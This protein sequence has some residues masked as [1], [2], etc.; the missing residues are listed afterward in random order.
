MKIKLNQRPV[1][2]GLL[3]ILICLFC[4]TS[5]SG[6]ALDRIFVSPKFYR[7]AE[8]SSTQSG[9]NGSIYVQ[10]IIDYYGDETVPSVVRI[11]ATGAL[12]RSFKADLPPSFIAYALKTLPNGNLLV[13]DGRRVFVLSKTGR[14]IKE[15]T[16]TN[17][18][19]GVFPMPD[20]TFFISTWSGELY[21]YTKNGLL[22]K[23]FKNN[24]GF[25]DGGIMAM[26]VQGSKIVIGGSFTK[27]RNT[28]QHNIARILLDGTLDTTFNS[29]G[30]GTRDFIHGILVQPDLKIIPFGYIS[31]YN[32]VWVQ[33]GLRLN[34]DG[35]IDESFQHPFP[36]HAAM[37]VHYNNGLLT[38]TLFKGIYRTYLNGTIDN[39]FNPIESG[40][41]DFVQSLVLPDNSVIVANHYSSLYR[42]SKF[43]SVGNQ[44]IAFLT[45]LTTKGVV[46]T[47]DQ[48]GKEIMVG[49]EF[50][51]VD[52]VFTRN[53]ARLDLQGNVDATFVMDNDQ[54]R[55]MQVDM[56][57]DRS[58]LVNSWADF[59]KVDATGKVDSSFN[60][61][62]FADLYQVGDFRRLA[63]GKIYALGYNNNY[64]LNEDGS[65]DPTFDIAEGFGGGASTFFGF[66]VD[67]ENKLLYGNYFTSYQ[68]ELAGRILR[69]NYDGSRDVTFNIGTGAND[70]VGRIKILTND[71]ILVTG[72]FTEFNG[73]LTP[74]R[75]III[76]PQGG[77]RNEFLQNFTENIPSFVYRAN[78][79][80]NKILLTGHNNIN[81]TFGAWN[82]D[83]SWAN[84][85]Q[86]PVEIS[87]WENFPDTYSPGGDTL[88]IFGGIKMDAGASRT[89]IVRILNPSSMQSFA[90]PG[91]KLFPNPVQDVM[92]V[93]MAE[94]A[95]YTIY[96]MSGHK[97]IR[98]TLAPGVNELKL[99]GLQKGSYIIAVTVNGKIHRS[100]FV[101]D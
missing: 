55:T 86:L 48:Q 44:V 96:D 38:Y 63:N 33:A 15:I 23:K 81:L 29:R 22:D 88:Y 49:G 47:M 59:S 45:P 76:S 27:V 34:E 13:S 89:S 94:A 61:T 30:S 64:R 98:A 21:R 4:H 39:S 12:D 40:P 53:V 11:S 85:F 84:D 62:P 26:A 46:T 79:F 32:D 69:I 67:K 8:I 51:K 77:I 74:K 42:I 35:S 9:P 95:T 75:A 97:R 37:T 6:Q 101:K 87:D 60:F 93:D 58:V 36:F 31:T 73:T 16:M 52:N 5:S 91:F 70:Q 72:N 3:I 82:L 43:N 78:Q 90:Q 10:G 100:R 99:F 54:A 24:V 83:G 19:G 41:F 18:I 65:W 17:S 2:A 50:F 56:L 57:P 25:T 28:E 20:N 80:Q 68:N 92:V 66:D 7:A 71:D 14:R 1:F